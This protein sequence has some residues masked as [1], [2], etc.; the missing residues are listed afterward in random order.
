VT[1]PIEPVGGRS[2]SQTPLFALVAVVAVAI[3]LSIAKPWSGGSSGGGAD[4]AGGVSPSPDPG[5]SG[6]APSAAPTPSPT[7]NDASFAFCLS[8]SGW[9]ITAEER[10]AGRAIREWQTIDP[11]GA[12]SPLD[13]ALPVA[14]VVSTSV[15]SLG[16]CA[17]PSGDDRPIGPVTTTIWHLLDDGGAIRV[18][19]AERA[20]SGDLGADYLPPGLDAPAV[21][22]APGRY[23]FDVEGIGYGDSHWFAAE[24]VRYVPGAATSTSPPRIVHP[25]TPT[26]PSATPLP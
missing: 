25:V 15:T 8:P 4:N 5:A 23:V 11:I 7:Q 24:V 16:W 26:S 19:P 17:P 18:T 10:F 1:T 14:L 2:R 13:P 9:R 6:R 3:G 21:D 22:W 20:P 12:S